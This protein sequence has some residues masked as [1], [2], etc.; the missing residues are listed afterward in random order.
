MFHLNWKRLL[1][2]PIACL[3]FA[4]PALAQDTNLDPPPV[5]V[6]GEEPLPPNLDEAVENLLRVLFAVA[7]ALFVDAPV[8]VVIVSIIKRIAALDFFNAQTWTAIVAV[9]LWVLL[10][11]AQL[12]GF[13]AEFTSLLK[14]LETALPAIA[15]LVFAL[16]GAG[17]LYQFGVKHQA[18]VV[19]YQKPAA[20]QKAA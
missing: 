3:S 5:A 20:R 7:I 15:A 11:I 14:I 6:V 8:T 10:T 12:A 17:G 2:A 4:L 9:V 19:S 16:L 1:I 13:E 18:A